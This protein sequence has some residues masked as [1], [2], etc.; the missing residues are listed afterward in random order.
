MTEQININDT[1]E[2]VNNDIISYGREHVVIIN[3][4]HIKVK[5][6]GLIVYAKMSASL[7][8]LIESI[9]ELI[10]SEDKFMTLNSAEIGSLED[11]NTP[12]AARTKAFAEIISKLIEKNIKQIITLLDI[13]V[14]ELGREYIENEV[15]LDDT[16]VLLDAIIGVNNITKVVTD[17]KKF[18]QSLLGSP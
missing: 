7:R 12:P 13:A 10:Q 17:G 18:L 8:E 4:R 6:L 2:E 14:P 11:E 5:K 3:D 16:L 15:G 9:I 1:N